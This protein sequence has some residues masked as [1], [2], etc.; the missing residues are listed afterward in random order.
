[1]SMSRAFLLAATLATFAAPVTHSAASGQSNAVVD[2]A[3]SAGK[4][5]ALHGVN[6]GPVIWGANDD[7]TK[8]HTDA[9]FPSTRCLHDSHWPAPTWWTFLASFRF[10]TPTPTIRKYYC[11]A[12]DGRLSCAIVKNG[13][14]ITYR[15]G[16]SIESRLRNY[17]G[18][19]S[20]R[21]RP[22]T[23]RNGRKSASTSSATTTKAGPTVTTTTSS[24][25]RSGTSRRR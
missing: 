4:I 18:R 11:F 23:T 1:M 16:K 9:G 2:F 3:K 7:L 25:S 21:T 12:E 6:N 24:T 20:T 22:R 13:S 10:S 8:Y 17:Q 14:Q 19:R 15:L 5:R